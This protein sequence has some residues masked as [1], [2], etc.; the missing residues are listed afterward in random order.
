MD[1]TVRTTRS[2]TIKLMRFSHAIL[3]NIQS[4][5]YISYYGYQESIIS[6]APVESQNQTFEFEEILL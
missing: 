1:T 3:D 4:Q 6:I 5:T 2:G